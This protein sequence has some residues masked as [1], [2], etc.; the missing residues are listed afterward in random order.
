MTEAE[1]RLRGQ[2]GARIKWSQ[3]AD[4]TEATA[5]ARRAFLDRFEKLADP[6]GVLAP[7]DRARR[8]E[9]LRKA[10]YARMAL[11]SV[12]ARRRRAKVRPRDTRP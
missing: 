8:A 4:R 2:I 12:Q 6:D 9:D 1:K 11:K 5:A 10:H 7:A 3:C